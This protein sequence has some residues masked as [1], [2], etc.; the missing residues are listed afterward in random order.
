MRAAFRLLKT[1][2]IRGE[3]SRQPNSRIPIVAMNICQIK[4]NEPRMNVVEVGHSRSFESV[5]APN[6]GTVFHNFSSSIRGIRLLDR[7]IVTIVRDIVTIVRLV[8]IC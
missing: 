7:D 6:K 5:D 8:S 3:S 2:V 4:P 1:L